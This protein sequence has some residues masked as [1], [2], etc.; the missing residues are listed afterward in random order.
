MEITE[1]ETT[2]ILYRNNVNICDIESN[3][4]GRGFARN[5]ERNLKEKYNT[6]RTIIRTF[7]QT[8]NKEAR[9]LSSATWI[10]ENFYMPF[11][12]KNKYRE[13]YKNISAFQKKGK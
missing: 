7:T 4:G 5:V 12:W 1:E 10:T 8:G 9:I 2:D 13:A 11:N 3:N 6:N